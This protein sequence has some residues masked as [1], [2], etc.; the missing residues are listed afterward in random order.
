M[1]ILMINIQYYPNIEGGAEISTQKLAEG[2]VKT[3]DV[4]VLRWSGKSNARSH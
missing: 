2:L 4:S 1:K 3:N